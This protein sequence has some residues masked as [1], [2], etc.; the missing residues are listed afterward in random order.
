MFRNS[1]LYRRLWYAKRRNAKKL[2]IFL[3]LSVVI[4][5]LAI[6]VTYIDRTIVPYIMDISESKARAIVT[7]AINRAVDEVFT[8]NRDHSEFLL[9][10]RDGFGG[11]TSIETDVSKINR[12]SGEFSASL[13]N[14]LNGVE[15]I[16][17]S[18]PLGVLLRSTV[19]AG[20]G[21][22]LYISLK[23]CGNIETEIKSEFESGM[24]NQTIHRMYLH[25]S[26]EIDIIAPLAHRKVEISKTVP[27]AETVIVTST[28]DA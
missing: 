10:S 24:A 17:I 19:F 20:V 5:I 4:I 26:A 21:P 25:V 12:L 18:I 11:I 16:G 8:E 6:F 22:E 13:Q 3:R 27:V 28:P 14:K 15:K 9:L 23:P 1:I 7:D 2:N